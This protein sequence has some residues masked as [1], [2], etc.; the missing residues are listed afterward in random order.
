MN[1]CENCS[2]KKITVD[3]LKKVNEDLQEEIRQLKGQIALFGQMLDVVENVF[4][5]IE[6]LPV[7]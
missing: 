5:H 1:D 2:E 3:Y 6:G 4:E 7:E